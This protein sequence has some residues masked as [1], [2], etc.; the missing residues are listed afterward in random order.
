[1]KQ[2][3]Q[4]HNV[5]IET[6]TIENFAVPRSSLVEKNDQ[7]NLEY[8]QMKLTEPLLH[9]LHQMHKKENEI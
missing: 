6:V 4:H 3:L 8:P 5:S 2:R 7:T 1:M 9:C